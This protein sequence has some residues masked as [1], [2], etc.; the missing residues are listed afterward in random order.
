[1]EYLSLKSNREITEQAKRVI[2]SAQSKV[3]AI[4]ALKSITPET[5][6]GTI[7]KF[8]SPS[9][10]GEKHYIAR[11]HRLVIAN[12]LRIVAKCCSDPPLQ[13][14]INSIAAVLEKSTTDLPHVSPIVADK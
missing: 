2:F 5:L 6:P 10:G 1:M 14:D 4:Q 11:S 9:K 13:N 8:A 3:D 12:L 7:E